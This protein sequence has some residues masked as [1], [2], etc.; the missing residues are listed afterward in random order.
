MTPSDWPTKNV[1][2][3]PKGPARLRGRRTRIAQFSS[4]ERDNL[5][6]EPVERQTEADK[7]TIAARG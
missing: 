5:V 3:S 1:K 7:L 4:A 6:S 2:R